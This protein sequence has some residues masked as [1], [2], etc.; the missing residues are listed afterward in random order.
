LFTSPG[1][2]ENKCSINLLKKMT[3]IDIRPGLHPFDPYAH[4]R[5]ARM[6]TNLS[7]NFK[8]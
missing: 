6:T 7:H 3:I 4:Q 8:I 1:A 2:V 5:E